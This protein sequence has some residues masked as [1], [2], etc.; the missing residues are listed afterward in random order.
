MR[1]SPR[2]ILKFIEMALSIL[3][4][5]TNYIMVDMKYRIISYFGRASDLKWEGEILFLI[6]STHYMEPCCELLAIFPLHSIYLNMI[7]VSDLTDAEL[8][9]KRLYCQDVLSVLGV[10]NSGDSIKKGITFITILL[11]QKARF[12]DIFKNETCLKKNSNNYD[13]NIII[14]NYTWLLS[15]TF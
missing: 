11:L 14:Y 1:K 7:C 4:P 9:I 3:I 12:T 13:Y 2:E 8:R 10:L 15:L 6:S 5:A